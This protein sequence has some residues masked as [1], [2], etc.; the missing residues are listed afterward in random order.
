MTLSFPGTHCG[1]AKIRDPLNVRR[2]NFS[3]VSKYS[4]VRLQN[5]I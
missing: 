1:G 4:E 2:N 3:S 5:L